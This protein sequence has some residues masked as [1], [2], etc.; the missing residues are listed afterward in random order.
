MK[1]G[2]STQYIEPRGFILLLEVNLTFD[3]LNNEYI[4][5]TSML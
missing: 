1:L 5:E 4:D 2:Q 3:L